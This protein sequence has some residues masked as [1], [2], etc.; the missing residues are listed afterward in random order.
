MTITTILFTD[1]VGSSE[2]LS[3]LGDQAARSVFGAHHELTRTVVEANGGELV[4]WQGDGVMARF[5]SAADALRSAIAIQRASSRSTRGE[6][7]RVRAGVHVG[8]TLSW[9][10]TDL[11]GM[12][13][14]V[15]RR[16][17]E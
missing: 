3:R 17:C 5:Q 11:F 1:L 6:Q 13:V 8:E 12:P 2:L 9:E 15:A 16:L 4:K 14:V 10:K 7:L